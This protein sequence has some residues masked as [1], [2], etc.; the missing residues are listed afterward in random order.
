MAGVDL[1]TALGRLLGNAA[2]RE[3]FAANPQALASEL[4]LREGDRDLFLQLR[5]AELE[6]QAR[7]LL[8]KRFDLVQA[9]LPRTCANLGTVA[10]VLFREYGESRPPTRGEPEQSRDDA[11]GFAEH[12]RA[13]R[14]GALCLLEANRA[15]FS[16]GRG[17][18]KICFVR[19]RAERGSRQ[20][21]LQIFLRRRAGGF[22]EWQ[23]RFGL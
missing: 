11:V 4:Q 14:P 7:V 6:F 13:V 8:R 12:V 2:M 20:P 10:W 9:V 5:P 22:D 3:A 19:A 21:G 23:I 15:R 1:V 16:R 17:Q 18:A